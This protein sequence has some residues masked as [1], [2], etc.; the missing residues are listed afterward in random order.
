VVQL[1]DESA[2][3]GTYPAADQVCDAHSWGNASTAA[4]RVPAACA[5]F[6]LEGRDFFLKPRP[7]YTP[8]TYLHPLR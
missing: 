1:T 5:T 2:C 6:L 3:T 8:F 4:V 7:A